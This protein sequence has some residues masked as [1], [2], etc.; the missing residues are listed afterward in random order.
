MEMFSLQCLSFTD[1]LRSVTT[2]WLQGSGFSPSNQ[3]HTI[4][5]QSLSL[6]V[7]FK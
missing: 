2:V 3:K 5:L 6:K 7:K 1:V 4:A